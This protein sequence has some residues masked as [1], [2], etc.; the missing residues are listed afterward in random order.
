MLTLSESTQEKL[1]S[2]LGLESSATDESVST[3]LDQLITEED[4]ETL[5]NRISA[6]ET[7]QID[8]LLD[9]HHVTDAAARAK[10]TK[11]LQ[12]LAN[13][14]EREEFLAILPKPA[15][16]TA[17]AVVKPPLTNRHPA[18]AP[19]QVTTDDSEKA[20]ADKKGVLIRNRAAELAKTQPN[21]PPATL[22]I[23]AS[24]QVEEELRTGVAK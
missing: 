1:L 23:Q 17:T 19:G 12:P 5:H 8:G 3:A 2:V 24:R 22:Y 6:L 21:T 18:K 20:A 10:L 16:T 15:A 4:L 13:R 11:A 9:A 14:K 7:E